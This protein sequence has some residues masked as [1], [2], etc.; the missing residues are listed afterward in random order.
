MRDAAPLLDAGFNANVNMFAQLKPKQSL[1]PVKNGID[2]EGF[3]LTFS[4]HE[5]EDFD[6][7]KGN[8]KSAK[9]RDKL[10]KSFEKM[11]L[12]S[13]A[14]INSLDVY[15]SL[16]KPAKPDYSAFANYFSFEANSTMM[17][18]ST[19]FTGLNN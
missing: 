12:G 10:R 4:A 7:G 17:E 9:K 2:F 6:L 13:D 14:N 11:V 19:G 8:V 1:E 5:E 16:K 18:A 3:G 15:K